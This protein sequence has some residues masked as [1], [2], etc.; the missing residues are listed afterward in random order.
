MVNRECICWI[1][2]LQAGNFTYYPEE[3]K[4]NAKGRIKASVYVKGGNLD[5][6][7]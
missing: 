6:S 5:G 2:I 7:N 3:S 4:V 1:D